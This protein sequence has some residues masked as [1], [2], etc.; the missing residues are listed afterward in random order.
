MCFVPVFC[1]GRDR[2][3][4]DS[5]FGLWEAMFCELSLCSHDS[6]LIRHREQSLLQ[7]G[8]MSCLRPGDAQLRVDPGH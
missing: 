7:L 5:S 3:E 8:V 1:C 4:E 2:G 6:S